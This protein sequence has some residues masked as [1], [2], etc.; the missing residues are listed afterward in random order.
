M[1]KPEVRDMKRSFVVG[2]GGFA[3]IGFV[4]YVAFSAQGGISSLPIIPE[5]TV[6]AAFTNV[7]SLQGNDLVRQSSIR[8]G[9]VESV[10][11]RGGEAVVKMRLDDPDYKIYK[12]ATAQIWDLNALGTKFVELSPGTPEAGPLGDGVIPSA[13]TEDSYDLHQ[14]LSIFDDKTKAATQALMGQV[15]GGMIGQGANFHDFLSKSDKLLPDLGTVS[16]ALASDQADLPAL[17]QSAERLTGRF[18][19][20]EAE[21]A[22]LIGQTNSTFEAINVG[23][24][25]QATL[26]RSSQTLVSAKQAFDALDRPLGDTE[27]MMRDFKPGADSLGKSEENLRGTL[28]D[29]IEPL[30]KL[31]DVS[32]QAEPA[33][34]DLKDTFSEAQP[35]APRL[36]RTLKT[37]ATPLRVLEPYAPEAGQWF[38]RF[39]SFVSLGSS[40]GNRYAYINANGS[41]GTVLSATTGGCV[42]QNNYPEPGAADKDRTKFGVPSGAPCLNGKTPPPLREA[43]RHLTGFT[44]GN[45]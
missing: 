44:G 6:R 25:L 20:R 18:R 17:L 21:I 39:A 36:A 31:P 7:D 28:R 3:F 38:V 2:L 45:K 13:Q 10:D 14:V 15:G 32:D 1:A 33:L 41:A 27:V 30:G 43:F 12:N 22:S 35:L 34:G 8:I 11:Y 29:G 24:A 23:D 42:D 5:T 4:I 26:D 40:D 37:A 9:A 16:V 19:A